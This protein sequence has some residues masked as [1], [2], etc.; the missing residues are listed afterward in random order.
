MTTHARS[1]GNGRAH[2]S[3]SPGDTSPDKPDTASERVPPYRPLLDD[4]SAL[5][6]YAAYYVSARIDAVKFRVRKALVWAAVG[7]MG[8]VAGMV[9][10]IG[11]IVFVLDG[12]AAG[13]AA[14]L[15]GRRWAG[16]LITGIVIL[17]VIALVGYLAVHGWVQ[18]SWHKTVKKYERRRDQER[19][20]FGRD[21]GQQAAQKRAAV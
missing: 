6:E 11:A 3:E 13:L 18:S 5:R 8:M 17:G 10:L 15:G 21:V 4:L 1:S 19:G 14:L 20:Q 12:I 7:L 16:D 9:V 2:S